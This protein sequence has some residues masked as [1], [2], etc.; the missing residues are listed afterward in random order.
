M[1][2]HSL[3]RGVLQLCPWK[4]DWGESFITECLDRILYDMENVCSSKKGVDCWKELMI[5]LQCLGPNPSG[6]QIV[7]CCWALRAGCYA[8]YSLCHWWLE[9]VGMLLSSL[10]LCW[11]PLS[12][13][14]LGWSCFVR[15]NKWKLN[16]DK[17][18]KD[19]VLLYKRRLRYKKEGKT[20]YKQCPWLCKECLMCPY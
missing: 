17:S 13:L 4:C 15:F 9:V 11:W 19:S 3:L 8:G 12:M 1:Q 5:W 20:C 6:M 10:V 2:C 18:Q 7:I 14:E 16:L